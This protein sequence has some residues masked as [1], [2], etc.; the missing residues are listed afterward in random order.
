MTRVRM[1]VPLALL[2]SLAACS[3][4]STSPASADL[5]PAYAF[6]ASNPPPPPIDTGTAPT[7][8]TQ[9]SFAVKYFFNPVGSSGYLM[10]DKTQEGSTEIDKNAQ[11][12]FHNGTFSGKGSIG[13]D[14][15]GAVAGGLRLVNRASENRGLRHFAG[16]APPGAEVE[17]TA[18]PD[19]RPDSGCFSLTFDGA[20][21]DG[22]S[23]PFLLEPA[24]RQD[25]PRRICVRTE[26]T[27]T[28]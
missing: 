8:S 10:F 25:D 2:A 7:G 9:T 3:N 14:T 15:T 22:V 1:M 26:D 12:R 23:I 6:F 4:E 21:L 17:A 18:A 24:C 11:V 19:D 16:C 28:L 13:A 27:S 5:D 20:T